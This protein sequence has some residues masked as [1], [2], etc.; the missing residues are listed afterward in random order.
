LKDPDELERLQKLRQ[1]Q[2]DARNPQTK[3]QKMQRQIATKY[4]RTRSGQNF[5]RD[6]WKGLD[7][8]WKGLIYGTLIGV[9]IMAILPFFISGMMGVL[10]GFAAIPL[11]MALGAMLGG[12]LDW[13]DSMRDHM[14]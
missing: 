4:K 3:E 12:S 7:K 5:F 9:V 6:S 13:R 8:I 11:M 14:K 10:L 2:L 1:S